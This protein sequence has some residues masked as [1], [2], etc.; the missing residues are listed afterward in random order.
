[1]KYVYLNNGLKMP[2]LGLGVYRC[3]EEDTFNTVK[4][5]ID[6][7]YRLIDTASAYENEEFVG[8]AIKYCGV[9]REDLF[10][11]TKL[12][13][14]DQRADNQRKAFEDSLKRLNL[15]YI[16]LYLIHWPVKEKFEQS[17]IELSKIYEEGLVR[18]VGVSN[19]KEHHLD[20]LKEISDLTPAVNQVEIHPKLTQKQLLEDCKKRKIQIE[21]WSPLGALKNNILEN[22]V[23]LKIAEKYNKTPAQIILRWDIECGIVTIPKSSNAQRQKQNINIFDFSLTIED[24]R[25][26]D[27]INENERTGSDPDNFTF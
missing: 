5:A 7:G 23:L 27:N 10:I 14:D 11:T 18:A 8:E 2:M 24:I 17:W 21:A 26:I 19:F 16:D 9:N 3:S 4:S 13:N 25:A 22:E 1:M 20:K 15:D 12:K 6:N